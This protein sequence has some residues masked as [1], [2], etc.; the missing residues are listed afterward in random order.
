MSTMTVPALPPATLA[1]STATVA[2]RPQ[3]LTAA[4]LRLFAVDFA[5]MSSFYLLV[6]VVPLF[7]TDRD[8][9]P[10]GAGLS[11]GVLMAASVAGELGTPALATRVGYRRLLVAGLVLLGAPA[12]A[13]PAVTGL[14]GLLVV[15]VARG[16]GFAVVVVAIGTVAATT[17]PEQRRGEGLGL[18]GLMA[19]LPSIL[20]LPLGVWLV[21]RLGYPVVFSLGAGCALV[22]AGVAVGLPEAAAAED[23]HGGGL[24]ATLRRPAL[25]RPAVL[26]A[27]AAVA[28]GVVVTFLPSAVAARVAVPALFV[29]SATAS[30][31]RWL[32]GRF[33]DRHGAA[34]LLAPSLALSA[35]GM[36]GAACTGSGFAVVAGMAVFGVGF[37]AAQAA[38]LNTMLQR[39]PRA[40]YGAVSAAWNASYDLGWGAGAIGIG[41]AVSNA[42][43]SGAFVAS[44]CLVLVALP[45]STTRRR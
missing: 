39:A 25:R 6:A 4:V 30:A 45:L 23:E 43:Y 13:L 29:Q 16:F 24:L 42:G 34:R 28:S 15:S 10:T 27:A 1:A 44:A 19:T 36:L 33:S 8:L 18:L 12:L 37:G 20:T 32:A 14:G 5:A 41:V 38:S 17:I 9:G 40:Q 31:A 22:A 3:L 2:T 11:I 26:F 35:A 21:G 7:S